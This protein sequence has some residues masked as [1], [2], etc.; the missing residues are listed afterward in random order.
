MRFGEPMEWDALIWH[1]NELTGVDPMLIKDWPL[2]MV[3][4]CLQ[5]HKGKAKAERP[6]KK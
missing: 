5:Y 1:I 3:L 2:Q 6:R 4:D